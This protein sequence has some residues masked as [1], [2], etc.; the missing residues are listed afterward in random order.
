MMT[1]DFAGTTPL[2][3]PIPRRPPQPQNVEMGDEN[4][5]EGESTHGTRP[6][7]TPSPPHVIV[8]PTPTKQGQGRRNT[9]KKRDTHTSTEIWMGI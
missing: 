5:S 8:M 7:A 2:L 9:I 3:R 4:A 1:P 6:K